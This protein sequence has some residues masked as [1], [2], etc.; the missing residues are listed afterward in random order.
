[1]YSKMIA[2][3]HGVCWIFFVF[4]EGG[5]N[6]K[7]GGSWGPS[8]AKRSC[9]MISEGMKHTSVIL[10]QHARDIGLYEW[11][12]FSVM[13][14]LFD[15]STAVEYVPNKPQKFH[16]CSGELLNG[17]RRKTVQYSTSYRGL[18]NAVNAA[19]WCC[20]L[21]LLAWHVKVTD[22]RQ[23]QRSWL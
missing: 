1:M 5:G 6:N 22:W 4:F 3:K 12:T 15:W 10:V 16:F 2:V 17:R 18:I 23:Y 9:L 7:F 19:D 21:L 20:C 14:V 11:M 13:H 8:V